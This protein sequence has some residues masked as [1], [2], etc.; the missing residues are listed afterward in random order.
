MSLATYHNENTSF[1]M[2]F[3]HISITA[4]NETLMAGVVSLIL[5]VQ[6]G[7]RMIQGLQLARGAWDMDDCVVVCWCGEVVVAWWCAGVVR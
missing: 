1:Y 2:Y 5:P 7:N 6:Y 3:N 4:A